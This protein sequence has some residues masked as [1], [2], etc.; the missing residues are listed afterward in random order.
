MDDDFG[1]PA[2]LAVIH[3]AV[4]DGNSAIAAGADSDVRDELGSVRRML[5][6]LG[7]DPLDEPWASRAQ[8]DASLREVVD[9]L[10]AAQLELREQARTAKDFARSDAIR[11]GL[12]ASGVIIED[13]PDGARWTLK[14]NS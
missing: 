14:D 10:V 13:T 12:A 7:I 2:A 9:K 6:L 3:D 8:S 5:G 1:V 4:R 11:D